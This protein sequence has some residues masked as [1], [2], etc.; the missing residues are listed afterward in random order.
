MFDLAKFSL[1]EMTECGA[2]IR[3]LGTQGGSFEEVAVR[4]VRYLYTHLVDVGTAQPACALVRFFKTHPYEELTPDLQ[5]FAAE[6]LGR[7]PDSPEMKC[8]ALM[9][10]AG[11]LPE[12]NDRTRSARF[13]AI[14]ISG[15]GF[16]AQFPMFSQLMTQFGVDLHALLKP[17]SNLLVDSHETTFNVFFVPEAVGSP[18]VPGQDQFVIPFGVKSVLGF[19]SLLPSGELFAVILFSKILIARETADL[20]KTMALCAKLAVLPFDGGA[21]FA[22][23]PFRI[24]P[25]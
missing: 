6:R 12:W 15:D 24:E 21:L 13:K 1:K 8:F 18:Y 5:R 4:T 17:S 2:D 7:R 16:V 14:P 20:F 9:A 22:D 11:Q 19:G 10:S 25:A 23:E 3:R